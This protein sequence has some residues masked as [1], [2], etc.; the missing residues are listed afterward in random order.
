MGDRDED[1]QPTDT[2][3]QDSSLR[4]QAESA[5]YIDTQASE[6]IATSDPKAENKRP[7]SAIGTTTDSQP[8]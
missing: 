8:V 5:I 7:G 1:L 2:G 6:L 3:T 4:L